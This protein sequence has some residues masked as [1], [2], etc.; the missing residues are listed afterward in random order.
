MGLGSRR[1]GMSGDA[2]SALLEHVEEDGGDD[3]Q[4]EDDFLPV[5]ADAG[6]GHTA[7]DDGDD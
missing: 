7:P 5:F 1:E 3:E 4:A 6:L 2:G